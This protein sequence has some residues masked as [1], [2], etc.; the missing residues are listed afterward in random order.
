[1]LFCIYIPAEKVYN[2][3]AKKTPEE[4]IM[5]R[6]GIDLGGIN[7]AAG[8]VTE[9][10]KII[11]AKSVPTREPGDCDVIIAEKMAKLSL[12][13]IKENSLNEDDIALIGMG[14]PGAVDN[15]KGIIAGTANVPFKNFNMR[16][17]F[18]KYTKI[19]IA[20]GN[21]ANC[22]ALGEAVAGAAKGKSE[23]IV[24]TLGTGVGGGII[25]GG[26]MYVGF[27]GVAGE[28][29]HI[30]TH[31]G[32]RKCGCGRCGCF[33]QY[34]SASAIIRDAREALADNPDS[35]LGTLAGGDPMK[36]SGKIVFEADAKGD[37]TAKNVVDN[38]IE[39]LGDGIA[40]FVNIFQPE[41]V[42][43]GGGICN[44]GERLLAPLRDYVYNHCFG[45]GLVKLPEIERAML[46]NDAGIIGAAMM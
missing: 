41:I 31:R 8:L 34:A 13:L 23:V 36:I 40:N 22:A 42:L 44:A 12:D 2:K 29:G 43:I 16:E 37:V 33:E 6:I 7:I 4:L 17:F 21:D 30:V 18:A 38:Y 26:K 32:G 9:E 5:Y 1:M 28:L 35:L 39:E 14:I 25:T 20:L 24:V 10:G 46:G 3:L 27:N 11:A 19:P 15:V 45:K